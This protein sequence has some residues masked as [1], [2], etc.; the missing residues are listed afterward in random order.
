VRAFWAGLC[1]FLFVLCSTLSAI[2]LAQGGASSDP[3]P[4]SPQPDVPLQLVSPGVIVVGHGPEV[5]D[6]PQRS[7]PTFVIPVLVLIPCAVVAPAVR[8]CV[9][10]HVQGPPAQSTEPAPGRFPSFPTDRS[11]SI[12]TPFQPSAARSDSVVVDCQPAALHSRVPT[13][14]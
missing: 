14:R 7:N 12:G 11:K 13:R 4:A 10:T 2:T 8:E 6:V 9:T 1:L 5:P 3:P